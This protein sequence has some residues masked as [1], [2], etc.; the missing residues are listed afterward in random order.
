MLLTPY[1]FHSGYGPY[2]AYLSCIF[3]AGAFRY[4][5]NGYEANKKKV[6]NTFISYYG[7]V[8]EI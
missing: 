1:N 2:Q 4:I 8:Y 3:V 7:P 6:P 5:L